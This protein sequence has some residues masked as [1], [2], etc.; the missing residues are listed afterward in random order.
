MLSFALGPF[1][2]HPPNYQNQYMLV[3]KD[4][5]L[6]LAAVNRRVLALPPEILAE[7]FLF[8]LGGRP[9]T[10]DPTEAP[11]LLCAVCQQ[12][13]NIASTT[14]Q[15]WSSISVD[16]EGDPPFDLVCIWLSRARST[17]LSLC[18]HVY[19]PLGASFET[20]SALSG[21]WQDVELSGALASLPIN[22][23]YPLLEGLCVYPPYCT[24][25]ISSF[26]D[27]PK[28]RDVYIPSYAAMIWL[29]LHQLVSFRT[30]S[31]FIEDCLELLRNASNFVAARLGIQPYESSALPD[32][33]FPLHQLRSLTLSCNYETI[34]P[35]VS[36]ALLKCFKVPTFKT[37]A[38]GF[39]YDESNGCN[40]SP[41]LSLVSQSHFQLHTLTLSLIPTTAN[42]LIKCL[43]ATPTVVDLKLQISYH[44]LDLNPVLAQFTGHHDFLPKLESLHIALTNYATNVDVLVIVNVLSWRLLLQHNILKSLFE[45]RV[46]LAPVGLAKSDKVL[47]IGTGPGFWIMD[48]AATIDPSVPMVG[49]DIE[50]RLFPT[51]PPK[52]I[53]FWVASVTSLPSEWTDT[54]SLVHQRLLIMG[55][56]V[57]QWPKAIQEIHRV[58]RPGGWVQLTETVGWKGKEYVEYPGRPCLEKLAT[59]YQ[60][61]AELHNFDLDCAYHIPQMLQEA[62][63]VDI[64]SES[65]MQALGNGPERLE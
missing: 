9:N 36:V 37:L 52:N 24:R 50:P 47:E 16:L 23:N 29:P 49:T 19:E 56:E 39:E 57:P 59:M 41:F 7:I 22:G 61:L 2:N 60:H 58:L 55:L 40:I 4:G 17:P 15:L 42:D 27:A 21:Q 10:P 45:N 64:R 51:S 34:D 65:R 31:V 53:E 12:W 25:P 28:L 35:M 1:S 62:G 46:I 18:W 54:F 30:N 48:L 32:T 43:K 44:I 14:P 6:Q 5:W 20:I 33:I 38:L 3:N 26:C 8:C 11:L 13:R 63:F